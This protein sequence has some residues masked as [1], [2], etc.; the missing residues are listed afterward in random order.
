MTATSS[1]GRV[2]LSYD[3][4]RNI[5]SPEEKANGARSYFA[6]M[7]VVELLKLDTKANLRGYIPEHPGK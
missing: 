6:N 5:T 2:A 7:P 4:I 1:S 3:T